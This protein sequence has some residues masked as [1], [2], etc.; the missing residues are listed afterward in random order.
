MLIGNVGRDPEMRY[1]A[2]GTA[3]TSFSLAVNRSQR[4]PAGEWK[5]ETTWFNIVAWRDLAERLS[6]SV[7]KGK[8]IFVDGRLQI[9]SWDDDQGVK[10]ER[11][12]VVANQV[13]LLGSRDRGEGDG[14]GGG[15]FDE[16]GSGGG[17]FG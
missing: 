9:R 15:N 12:E 13:L 5:E 14:G 2:N 4:D 17:G 7:T 8:Q 1:T 11:I 10:H 6:Q 16:G 3:L